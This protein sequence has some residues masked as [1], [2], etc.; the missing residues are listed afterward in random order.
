MNSPKVFPMMTN[1][2][3]RKVKSLLVIIIRKT[4]LNKAVLYEWYTIP[5]SPPQ[6][7]YTLCLDSCYSL[8]RF[9]WS[10]VY[11]FH[12]FNTFYIGL[13]I[14]IMHGLD[15]KGVF[16]CSNLTCQPLKEISRPFLPLKISINERKSGSMTIWHKKACSKF[17]LNIA[18]FSFQ[19]WNQGKSTIF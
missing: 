17:M 14:A 16:Y 13:F 5:S 2:S 9:Q 12:F 19:W 7:E 1:Y 10:R 18:S 15:I 4:C 11:F 8:N 3:G 6:L